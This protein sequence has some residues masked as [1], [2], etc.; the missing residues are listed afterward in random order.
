MMFYLSDCWLCPQGCVSSRTI[1]DVLNKVGSDVVTSDTAVI[2]V[3]MCSLNALPRKF[4]VSLD[5]S[6][7]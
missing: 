2:S 5:L 6:H 1:E 7:G 4:V 3:F